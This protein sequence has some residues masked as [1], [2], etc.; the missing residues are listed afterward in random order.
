MA[1]DALAF[2]FD[3]DNKQ[4]LSALIGA[5]ETDARFD[6]LEIRLLKPRLGLSEQVEALARAHDKVV[7]G[8]SFTTPKARQVLQELRDLCRPD[9]VTLV[10]GGPH[11]SGAPRQTLGIDY[12]GAVHVFYS[13]DSWGETSPVLQPTGYG[14]SGD[15]FGY[16]V[17]IS[18]PYIIAGAPGMTL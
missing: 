8:F 1:S 14:Q 18:G 11:P 12:V 9:N 15:E 13:S 4:S 6:G 7:V 5:V 17:S 10:A 3:N 16:S 2:V